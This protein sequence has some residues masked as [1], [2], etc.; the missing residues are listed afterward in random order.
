MSEPEKPENS[1]K[2]ARGPSDEMR[3]FREYEEAKKR[4]PE[5]LRNIRD[6]LPELEGL[7]REVEGHWEMEDSF[8]RFYHQSFKVYGLQNLTKKLVET[9]ETLLPGRPLNK[10]FMKI[11][12]EGTGKQFKVEDNENWLEVTRPIVEAFFHA[13]YFLVLLCKYGRELEA[14]PRPL[15][16]GYAA[17]LYLY[18][19][20]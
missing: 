15:P 16:S 2:P 1:E 19:I 12:A 13:H 11:V 9:F 8:Y 20:R 18:E 7:L 14:P 4:E 3:R 6:R 17:I 10:W 5:L